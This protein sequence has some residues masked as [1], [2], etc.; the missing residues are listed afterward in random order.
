MTALN[1]LK[2]KYDIDYSINLVE[3]SFLKDVEETLKL[4]LG[5]E[6]REYI[7]R[8]GHIEYEYLEFM[9]VN[10][11]EK[12]NSD[13]IRITLR[14]H[15]AHEKTKKFIAFEDVADNVYTL[16]DSNDFAYRYD[17]VLDE[18]PV[19][20]GKKLSEYIEERIKNA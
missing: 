1:E 18:E 16:I 5:P 11:S 14:L 19:F 4:K 15:E 8:F 17:A 6:L 20:I 7:T 9:G 3:D 2:N 10:S 13:M 12:M